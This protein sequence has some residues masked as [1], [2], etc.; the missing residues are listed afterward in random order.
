[1]SAPESV[2]YLHK[3]VQDAERF[4]KLRRKIDESD[5]AVEKAVEALDFQKNHEILDFGCGEGSLLNRYY[6]PLAEKLN[7]KVVGLDISEAMINA[8]RKY[9]SHPSVEYICGDIFSEDDFP[10]ADRKFDRILSV[11]V[12]DYFTDYRHA[13]EKLSKLLKPGGLIWILTSAEEKYYHY[14]ER[15]RLHPV[16]SLQMGVPLQPDWVQLGLSAEVAYRNAVQAVGMELIE[17]ETS[18]LPYNCENMEDCTEF[19]TSFLS[20]VNKLS[21]EELKTLK[22][23]CRQ[24]VLGSWISGEIDEAKPFSFNY[25]MLTLIAKKI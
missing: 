20:S 8:A 9:H 2:T 14:Y 22:E 11:W 12:F 6:V 25:K 24:E 21:E 19:L 4:R 7:M 16:L 10:L 17:V 5:T 3:G 1:M 23:L 13:L 18:V 15:I